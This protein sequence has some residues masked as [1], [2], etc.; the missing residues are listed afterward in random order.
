[1][2]FCRPG[3]CYTVTYV[4]YVT[5]SLSTWIVV[6]FTVERFVAVLYPLQRSLIC[7]VH[8]AK[9]LVAFLATTIVLLN[10]PV[11]KFLSPPDNCSVDT[12]YMDYATRF[13]MI[14]TAIAFTAPLGAIIVLNVR[15]MKSVWRLE[16]ARDLLLRVGQ[17]PGPSRVR[18]MRPPG[19]SPQHR[20][21]RMLLIVSSVFVVLNLPAYTMRLMAYTKVS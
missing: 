3:V 4:S 11:F 19:A 13:N 8:R 2:H 1:M 15:I 10:L 20:V 6:A 16:H 18:H 17:Q 9:Y 14:D 5:S 21:T 7:T 12:A